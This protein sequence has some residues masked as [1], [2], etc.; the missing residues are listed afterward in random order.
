MHRAN[1]PWSP[2]IIIFHKNR[3]LKW[4]KS[5]SMGRTQGVWSASGEEVKN[6][7]TEERKSR[8]KRESSTSA[9]LH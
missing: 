5:Q 3:A 6:Q 1:H 2:S 9:P 8:V 4:T 7:P